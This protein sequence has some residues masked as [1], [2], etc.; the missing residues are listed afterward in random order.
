[1]SGEEAVSHEGLVRRIEALETRALR[2]AVLDR[3]TQISSEL[4]D[5]L[6]P[7]DGL[8]REYPLDSDGLIRSM[9]STREEADVLLRAVVL[10]I[11]LMRAAENAIGPELRPDLDDDARWRATGEL[12]QA[13][14]SPFAA[15]VDLYSSWQE[16]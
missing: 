5:R 4:S 11:A 15:F 3:V 10:K 1:M 13:V 9:A 7:S 6:K 12:A 8:V 14:W 16:A 2:E